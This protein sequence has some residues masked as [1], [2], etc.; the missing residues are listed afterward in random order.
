MSEFTA[1]DAAH[2]YAAQGWH[3]FPI[4]PRGKAPIGAVVPN[5]K[6][7][8][9][10][11]LP[12]INRWFANGH[13]NRNIGISCGP[14]SLLVID[15][16]LPKPKNGHTDGREKLVELE[17][18]L[19]K[20]PPTITADT[21]SGGTH[22][23]FRAPAGIEF[24]GKVGRAIDIIRNGYIVA[25]PSVHE[26]GHP[27]RWRAGRAPDEIDLAELPEA[28]VNHLRRVA[29]EAQARAPRG[30]AAGDD[31]EA[32]LKSLDQRRV[33]ECL[34]GTSAVN[35]ERFEFRR[36]RNG[37]W[38]LFVDRGDGP[39]G[40]SNFIAADGTIAARRTGK[41]DGGPYAWSWLRYYRDDDA[42]NRRALIEH[43]P[44]L[45]RWYEES[46]RKRTNREPASDADRDTAHA[47]DHRAGG[48]ESF[49]LEVS[50]K[51]EGMPSNASQKNIRIA[52]RKL[53]VSV[54]YDRF[55]NREIVR[56]LDGHGPEIDDAAMVRLHLMI[57]ERFSFRPAKEFFYDVVS[58]EARQNAYHPVLDYLGGLTW[59][60]TPRIARWLSTYGGAADTEYTRAVG[61]LV[62]VA[63]VRRVRQPGVKFDEMLVLESEQGTNKSSAMQALAVRDEW[64]IDDLPLGADTKTQ[65]ERM[66]GKWIVE[67]GELKG[68]SKGDVNALKSFLSRRVDEARLSYGRKKTTQPRQCVIVGTTNETAGY[69]RDS[70][71]NRR[72][73]PVRV[74]GFDLDRLRV[75]RDQ[76]WAE[77]AHVESTGASIRLDPALYTAAAHEQEARRIDDPFVMLLDQ[78][79]GDLT[80]KVRIADCWQI[81]GVKPGDATQDQQARLGAA[82]REL[83]WER[84]QRRYGGAPEWSYVKGTRDERER[85]LEV[86]YDH[87]A[88]TVT[89]RTPR[90]G[91]VS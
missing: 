24:V 9:S 29:P 4:E 76:L 67:A 32:A 8:A 90:N 19:G 21:G 25:A 68:M 28:W 44:E 3:V 45:A 58:D 11:D 64:F 48:D 55:A 7:D 14:A 59:D 23:L 73:W 15:V 51:R 63:A 52:M 10:T 43:V 87:G 40:T 38:N 46:K 41:K 6:D 13:G 16:D 81:V 31:F 17:E 88:L 83:G 71:G 61:Q 34:S 27:Y 65:M 89:P 69:L 78:A 62:L 85:G 20:L 74:G 5:G 54:R 82:M 53:G 80:G 79:F 37:K 39:E 66:A 49:E 70:T 1:L 26:S 86:M 84:V 22:Y 35:G 47:D 56:G 75:D 77:A 72:F 60:G 33:L 42:A 50:G 12:T 30:D 18:D 91:V 57:D 36:T 2:W